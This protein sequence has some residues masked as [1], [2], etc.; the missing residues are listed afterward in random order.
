M[1]ALL[2]LHLASAAS[3]AALFVVALRSRR[4]P[5][6]FWFSAV[7]VALL[8]WTVAYAL[9]LWAPG[10]TEK[11]VWANV[12]FIGATALPLAWL[13]AVRAAVDRPP[14]P[15][16]LLVVL[17]LVAVV[18]VACVFA[19]PHGLFR[20]HPSLDT[21]GPIAF[22]AADYGILYHVLWEPFAYGLVA[23]AL[24][25]LVHALCR[26]P[27]ELRGR[28]F[29]LVVGTVV[30]LVSGGLFVLGLLPWPNFNPAM[31][32]ISV[33]AILALCAI[34]YGY[35]F[36]VTPLARSKVIEQLAD[37]VVICDARGRVNDC[38]PA[39]RALLPELRNAVGRPLDEA[40][41][42]RAELLGVLA[43]ERSADWTPGEA[44]RESSRDAAVPG[45]AGVHVWEPGGEAGSCCRHVAVSST[46]VLSRRGRRLGE[47][48]ML[49]DVTGDVEALHE[50]RQRATTDELTGLLTRGRLF[51]LGRGELER[52]RRQGRSLGVLILDIDR[53]KE[54][55]DRFGHLAGDELLRGVASVCREELRSFDLL[56]RLG[57]DELAAVLPDLNP[58]EALMAA[59]R[60]RREVA[61]MTVGY[62]GKRLT[63]TVSVGVACGGCSGESLLELLEAADAAL[64]E[65]KAQGRDRVSLA[66]CAALIC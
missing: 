4:D 38:N 18:I 19:N 9:E 60:L 26:G 31:S 39:A 46:P 24:L 30:P 44:P 36:D 35:L 1:S 5:A 47:A 61:G 25:T 41:A 48:I 21:S 52:A 37:G 56:A 58:E 43:A 3:L 17:T 11:L 59:E 34:V 16:W 54:A 29:I 8:I 66:S 15:R 33:V 7:C 6:A 64:Y 55:N 42:G 32:S 65:A 13:L 45:V 62:R 49:R 20:G 51:E 22:V 27:R 50:L 40:L 10:L 23:A 57:G 53:F 14:L 28:A 63:A 2:I 12:Q